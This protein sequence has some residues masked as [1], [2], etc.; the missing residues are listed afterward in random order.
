MKI[1]QRSKRIAEFIIYEILIKA[2]NEY[3]WLW[4]AI[5]PIDKTILGLYFSTKKYVCLLLNN[6][7][8]H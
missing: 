4:I 6:W 2:G 5:E 3:M 8:N 7:Q 1:N